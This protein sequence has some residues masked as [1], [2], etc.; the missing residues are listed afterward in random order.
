MP[1]CCLFIV[2]CFFQPL[3]F[4]LY[5]EVNVRLSSER[6]RELPMLKLV[7]KKIRVC[8]SQVVIVVWFPIAKD[9]FLQEELKT[10]S[11]PL[12]QIEGSSPYYLTLILFFEGGRDIKRLDFHSSLLAFKTALHCY[13]IWEHWGKHRAQHPCSWHSSMKNS[14]YLVYGNWLQNT[15][16]K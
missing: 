5:A 13:G 15:T 7:S 16:W 4:F 9:V 8:C 1:I 3:G 11:W 6:V 10:S 12:L 14:K 2:S